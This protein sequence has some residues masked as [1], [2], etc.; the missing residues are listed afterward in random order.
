MVSRPAYP[1]VDIP[2]G[3]VPQVGDKI[4]IL[5]DRPVDYP[6]EIVFENSFGGKVSITYFN[7]IEKVIGEVLKPVAGVGRFE[8]TKYSSAGRIRANHAGVIDVSTSRLGEIG[9]FQIVPSE[10]GTGMEYVKATTQWMVIGPADINDPAYEGK[11]PF[12]KYFIRPA[13]AS[14]D[15]DSD[16]WQKK[17]LD[18]FLVEVKV[19]GSN[20]WQPMPVHEFDEYYLTGEVPSWANNALQNVTYIRIL[21][22]IRPSDQ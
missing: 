5:V 6:K 4:Y 21:F 12:F 2:R 11:A 14:T 18:R 13:Y 9:G 16:G 10:H 22:P 20:K 17:L 19:K 1:V 8:G 3:Y 7:G 15:L